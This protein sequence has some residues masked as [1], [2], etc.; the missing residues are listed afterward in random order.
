MRIQQHRSCFAVVLAVLAAGLLLQPLDA[1]AQDTPTPTSTPTPTN[2]PTVTPA[3]GA[4]AVPLATPTPITGSF[5]LLPGGS[6]RLDGSL[7]VSQG[8]VLVLPDQTGGNGLASSAIV[9]NV[10]CSLVSLGTLGNG[11]TET[12]LLLDDSP[13]GEWTA[14]DSSAVRSADTT[15]FRVGTT[16]LKVAFGADATAYDGIVSD[17][18]NDDWEPK[19]SVGFWIRVSEAVEA[20]DLLLRAEDTSAQTDFPLPA[21]QVPNV[22]TWVE[23]NISGLAGGTGNVVD[24]VRFLLS[25]AG[26]SN[27]G[28]F[29]VWLDGMYTW[30]AAVEE[31]LGVNLVPDGLKSVMVLATAAGSANTIT[32][33]ADQTDYF[34]HY[35]AGADFLVPIT[36]QSA[37]SGIGMACYQ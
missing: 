1:L 23:I 17:I 35:E 10:N 34:V 20:G 5:R 16:S 33:L 28:A 2:T 29:N 13:T 21:I 18:T 36:D 27:H 4:T 32:A 22:W 25:T 8:N 37:A 12:V 30:D 3:A 15:Y 19:E 24:K 11:T 26:A 14:V 31:A 9:G 6:Q 7:L